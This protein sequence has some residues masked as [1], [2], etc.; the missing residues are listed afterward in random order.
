VKEFA[1]VYGVLVST[2]AAASEK[3]TRFEKTHQET[4]RCLIEELDASLTSV[5][6][7]RQRFAEASADMGKSFRCI[8]SGIGT[9][10][11][12]LQIGDITRQRVE[13]IEEALA[14]LLERHA[15]GQADAGEFAA[16]IAAVCRL[17]TAQAIET[18]D[19]FDGEIRR[20]VETLRSLATEAGTI[21]EQSGRIHGAGVEAR[22]VTTAELVGE[23]QK[24]CTLIRSSVAT[25]EECDRAAGSVVNSLQDLMG[26][27]A[28]VQ[29]IEADMQIV[30]LNMGL[31]CARLGSQGHTLSIIAQELRSLT[32]QTVVYARAAIE[33][34]RAAAAM[35][36]SLATRSAAGTAEAVEALE[37]AAISATTTQQQIDR[38]LDDTLDT[39]KRDGARAAGLLAEVAARAMAQDELRPA[40]TAA[41][42]AIEAIR[43]SAIAAYADLGA[44]DMAAAE[45]AAIAQ[46]QSRYTMV[47][48]RLT[49]ERLIEG[50]SVTVA[51]AE[52]ADD[53]D[54]LFL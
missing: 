24:A 31:K 10:V 18:R 28:A 38:D 52:D 14:M 20:L 1:S 54:A 46:L 6:Q 4:M 36:Q 2:L 9:A 21:V 30:S 34:L 16:I 53:L 45:A 41:S 44:G 15:D 42:K 22:R 50:A 51:S 17:Q 3:Q 29:E 49:H 11:S 19:Q 12:A 47:S 48:E 40:L 32:A 37:A 35:A 33:N 23:V 7:S 43:D 27:V 39:L 25:R 26:C 8:A 13:H 5:D